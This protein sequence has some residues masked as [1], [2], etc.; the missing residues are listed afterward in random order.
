[1]GASQSEL[2]REEGREDCGREGKLGKCL[3]WNQM[4]KLVPESLWRG[5][6]ALPG[7]VARKRPWTQLQPPRGAEVSSGGGRGTY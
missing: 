1:M 3:F 7:R 4:I 6:R 2:E 5:Y